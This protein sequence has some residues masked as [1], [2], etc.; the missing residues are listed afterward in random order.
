MALD[1]L[2]ENSCLS[3]ED[4]AR[5]DGFMDSAIQ[6]GGD[7]VVFYDGANYQCK[8]EK[9]GIFGVASLTRSDAF[10]VTT[11]GGIKD[12]GP[13][14]SVTFCYDLKTGKILTMVPNIGISGLSAFINGYSA[15]YPVLVG[16]RLDPDMISRIKEFG[17]LEMIGPHFTG[18]FDGHECSLSFNSAGHHLVVIVTKIGIGTWSF[19]LD[20]KTGKCDNLDGINTLEIARFFNRNSGV[21]LQ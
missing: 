15:E 16:D 10:D 13:F 5:L 11:P 18:R 2:N 9:N 17:E 6:K 7:V 21:Q 8:C 1:S 3:E 4:L 20:T 12:G 19:T 14:L